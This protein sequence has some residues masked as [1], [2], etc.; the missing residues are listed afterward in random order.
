MSEVMIDGLV[1]GGL[2]RQ[3]AYAVFRLGADVHCRR[4]FDRAIA[5]EDLVGSGFSRDDAEGAID[6]ALASLARERDGSAPER[7][8]AK[9]S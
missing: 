6:R 2:T 4:A 3:Q 1:A 8:G 5:C 7:P 9:A